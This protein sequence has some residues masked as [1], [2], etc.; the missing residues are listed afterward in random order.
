MQANNKSDVA[1]VY[2][3]ATR[4]ATK[5]TKIGI[6]DSWK[7]ILMPL[8]ILSYHYFFEGIK[9]V[10]KDG[11]TKELEKITNLSYDETIKT[12]EKCQKDGVR[13]VASE[14]DLETKDSEFD[15]KKSLFQ[16]KRITRYSR[17]IKQLSNFMAKY[18]K[19]SKF[20]QL[21]K[22]IKKYKDIQENQIKEHKNQLYNI[23]FNK[24][25]APYM[26]DRIADLI[27]YRT[28]ISKELFDENTYAAITEFQ[29][30][31]MKENKKDGISLNTQQL[32]DFSD[33]FKLHEIGS[34]ETQDFKQD[35][36]IHEMPFSSF[37]SM[38]DDLEVTDIKYGIE[39][40]TNEENKK[41]ANIYFENK[42]LER[43]SELGFNDIGQ[44]RV[45]G[46]NNKNLQWNIQSQDELVSFKTK[47][48]NEEKQTYSTLS[49]KNYIMKRQQNEC[50]WTV[51]KADLK[52]LAEKEKKRDVVNEELENL[53]IFEQLEKEVSNTSGIV[54]HS[55]EIKVDFGQEIE[56]EGSD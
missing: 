31:S 38:K 24:S 19:A 56:K 44:I 18:P 4:A 34:V 43:Y 54:E 11:S 5:V 22:F 49:G 37:M 51:F 25:K 20:L 23:Y 3:G 16:Q 32:K 41:I 30:D 8:S 1:Q 10:Q 12:M 17:R 14:R 9:A 6:K 27:E 2:E 48:G 7:Y 55:N 29:N 36:C 28:G 35:Y 21:D 50:L 33:K 39:I 53:N 45:Y 13:V 42:N 46:N 26:G 40:T 52:E 15:K 47:V